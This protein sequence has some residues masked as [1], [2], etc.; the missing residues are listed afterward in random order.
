MLF[1]LLN[2]LSNR[3][4]SE[5]QEGPMPKRV[6]V[7]LSFFAF[8]LIG[9]CAMHPYGYN[10]QGNYGYHSQGSYVH[11]PPAAP[12]PPRRVIVR[13]ETHR[14]LT[15]QIIMEPCCRM[16]PDVIYRYY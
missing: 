11:I 2:L 6:K 13:T 16:Q 7:V 10:N 14:V 8:S 15:P 4:V 9:G 3:F 5:Y 1:N 12:Q